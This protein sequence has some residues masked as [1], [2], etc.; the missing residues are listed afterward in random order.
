MWSKL[1]LKNITYFV[2][3][4][5]GALGNEMFEKSCEFFLII[6][7]TSEPTNKMVLI[8]NKQYFKH[9]NLPL[10][11]KIVWFLMKDPKRLKYAEAVSK[12]DKL[13]L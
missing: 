7:Q 5:D 8:R 2:K 13:R 4:V 1:R 3:S 12:N 6:E 10:K 9:L 11:M